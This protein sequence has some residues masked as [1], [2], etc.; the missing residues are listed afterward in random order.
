MFSWVSP[1]DWSCRPR[2]SKTR[3]RGLLLASSW[4]L[5]G[6]S[7]APLGLLLGPLG[8]LLASFGLPSDAPGLVFYERFCGSRP[9]TCIV[10]LGA[11]KNLLFGY[12]WFLLASSWL[13]LGSSWLALGASWAPLGLL[14]GSSWL[15]LGFPE[16]LRD[17][18]F[19]NVFV[20]LALGPVFSVSGLQKPPLGLFLGS[21]W[22]PLG[23]SW[24][25]LGLLLAPLGLLLGSPETLQDCFLLAFLWVSPWDL[26]F[27]PRDSKKPPLGLFLGSSLPP[28]GSSWAPL[29]FLLAPLGL[30]LGTPETLQDL[31]FTS[32][33]VGLAL[34]SVFVAS[35]LR[36]TSSCTVFGLLLASCWAPL[37]LP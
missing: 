33:F 26:Y 1:W 31:F 20:G 6:S 34:G 22:P 9:G 18:I 2:G 17:S 35:G 4:L 12:S 27:R 21:S 11:Q 19:T 8:F 36:K 3:L 16:T 13:L 28:L 25:P 29:G 32:V 24:A 15:L 7:W 14:L 37:G 23:S 30:L 10:G 5:L